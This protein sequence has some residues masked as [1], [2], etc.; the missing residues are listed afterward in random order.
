MW[1]SKATKK[2]IRVNFTRGGMIRPYHGIVLHIMDGFLEGTYGWFNKTREQRQEDYDAKWEREG[3]RTAAPVKA[4][5]SS[6]HFGVSVNGRLW[7]FVDTDHQAWAQDSGNP[8][9][10][11]I[12]CEGMGGDS[13]SDL[14]IDAVAKFVL[15]MFQEEKVPMQLANTPSEFGLGF[16]SMSPDWHKPACPGSNVIAQR[17]RII[18]RAEEFLSEE[19][20]EIRSQHS[21]FTN[22]GRP[23]RGEDGSYSYQPDSP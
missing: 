7:Q 1:F 23:V 16:H 21:P 10:I 15:W 14:Q 3:R 18:Q 11:S 19:I 13:L 4:Y 12:E 20:R 5:A 22:P 6:A 8:Y 9:W 2:E 17:A